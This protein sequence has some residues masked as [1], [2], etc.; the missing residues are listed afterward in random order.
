[1]PDSATGNER[2]PVPDRQRLAFADFLA[3]E[4]GNPYAAWYVNHCQR[5]LRRDF[6][7]RLYRMARSEKTYSDNKQLPEDRG[8]ALWLE[9]IGE[10]VLI[11]PFRIPTGI[12]S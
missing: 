1:M 5:D 6:E 2:Q 11:L 9:D 8:N 10:V 7:L 3:R 4:T 12:F